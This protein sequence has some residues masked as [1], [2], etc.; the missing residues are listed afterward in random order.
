MTTSDTVLS[1]REAARPR[2]VDATLI[3]GSLRAFDLLLLIVNG[4][5]ASYA[6][7]GYVDLTG[8]PGVVLCLVVAIA[9]VTFQQIGV[10]EKT[11]LRRPFIQVRRLVIGLLIVAA[12]AMAIGYA[13]KTAGSI[14]RLWI[15]LWLAGALSSLLAARIPIASIVSGLDA[16]GALRRRLVIAGT[17]RELTRIERLLERWQSASSD[18]EVI[19]AVFLDDPGLAQAR[20]FRSPYRLGGSFDDLV[21]Y[22][23]RRRLDGVLAVLPAHDRSLSA[24][25]IEKLGLVPLDVDLIAAELDEDWL[26]RPVS[27]QGGQPAVR[28][29][30]KPLTAT[31]VL[32][33]RV[34]DLCVAL[35]ALIVLAPAMLLIAL[36]IKV[37]SP[38]PVLFRQLRHGFNNR[39]FLVF[40]FRSMHHRPDVLA[41]VAQATRQ[42]ARVT[43]VGRVL[44]STSLDELPQLFNVLQG[45]MSIVGPRPHAV[46]HNDHFSKVIARYLAR[47]RIKPGITGWAQVNGLRGETETIDKMRERIRYDLYYADHWMLRFDLKIMIL[48]LPMLIHRN[49]Y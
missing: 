7:F 3:I 49:A 11:I 20:N 24:E 30:S 48:T 44:R 5:I 39:P 33:K 32:I 19:E 37:D 17:V 12:I 6:R 25:A 36:A 34:E 41:T 2:A 8:L 28:I 29:I 27:T 40:K 43:R 46:E 42:D 26:D 47:H 15:G 13:T 31:E 45:D 14:S 4:M 38:G 21:A 23:Q 16:S 35:L 10:Y 9:F 1:A 22:A 18:D